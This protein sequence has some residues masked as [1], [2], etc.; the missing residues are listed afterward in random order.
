M[1]LSP[2]ERNR[3]SRM[4]HPMRRFA[5]VLNELGLRDIPLQ[6]GLFT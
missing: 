3:A 2:N 1:V 4:S 5:E 6:G